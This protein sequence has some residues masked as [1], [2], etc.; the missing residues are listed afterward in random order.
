M[1]DFQIIILQ[2]ALTVQK[3]VD[4][5]RPAVFPLGKLKCFY[6][7]PEDSACDIACINEGYLSVH[8]LEIRCSEQVTLVSAGE[9][10]NVERTH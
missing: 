3:R 2:I 8:Y 5:I 6:L 10:G 1:K 4:K 7:C 9:T